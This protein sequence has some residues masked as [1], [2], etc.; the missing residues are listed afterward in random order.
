MGL[1]RT[2]HRFWVVWVGVVIAWGATCAQAQVPAAARQR[3][4]WGRFE[5]ESWKHVRVFSEQWDEKGGPANLSTT[6]TTS[7]LEK[8]TDQYYTLQLETSLEVGDKRIG[9]DRRSVTQGYYGEIAGQ[10]A[11]IRKTGDG[12]VVVQGRT[13][14]VEVSEILITAGG[15]TKR[16]S[17]VHFNAKVSPY[18]LKRVSTET[19]PES[20]GATTTT[21]EVVALDMPFRV[22][23]ETCAVTLIRTVETRPDG[24]SAVSY[25]AQCPDVPGGT[26]WQSSKV[27]NAA[28]QVVRRSVLE[29]L[30]FHVDGQAGDDD[31]DSPSS[32]RRRFHRTRPTPPAAPEKNRR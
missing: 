17:A 14:P 26:V 6:E 20:K 8:V 5:A 3:H 24:V 15:R 30:D 22:M 28:G 1:V 31:D 4:A 19:A 16:T 13:L 11:T 18:V 32:R 9:G 2:W 21:V 29:L 12:E 7:T 27:T 25:E 23:N 10:L